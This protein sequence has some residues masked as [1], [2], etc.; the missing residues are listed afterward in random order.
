M[1]KRRRLVPITQLLSVLDTTTGEVTPLLH[2]DLIRK[3][4]TKEDESPEQAAAQ[5][6]RNTRRRAA[7]AAQRD[8]AQVRA[9]EWWRPSGFWDTGDWDE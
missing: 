8:L 6:Q 7:R 3:D 2:T 1:S 9:D 5:D 4:E